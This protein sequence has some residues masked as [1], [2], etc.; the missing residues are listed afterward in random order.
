[1]PTSSWTMGSDSSRSFQI[2]ASQPSGRRTRSISAS[3][4]SGSN[5]WKAWATTT[6]STVPPPRGMCSAVAP[7]IGTP[8]TT[9]ANTSRME[10][11]GSAATQASPRRCSCRVSLPVPAARSSTRLDGGQPGDGD[12][13]VHGI[14]GIGGTGPLVDVRPAFEA[15]PPEAGPDCGIALFVVGHSA[16]LY[17]AWRLG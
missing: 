5:Q 12:Q 14:V 10:G 8:G 3:A 9:R 6:A 17:G 13:P 16:P 1:M 7:T 2:R 4:T 11:D 15:G